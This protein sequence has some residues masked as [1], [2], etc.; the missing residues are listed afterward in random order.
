MGNDTGAGIGWNG[1]KIGVLEGGVT[2]EIRIPKGEWIKGCPG[3]EG[4]GKGQ[5][6]GTR[7]GVDCLEEWAGDRELTDW[8]ADKGALTGVPG[9]D[10]CGEDGCFGVPEEEDEDEDED[11]FELDDGEATMGESQDG[12]AVDG[13]GVGESRLMMLGLESPPNAFNDIGCGES[14]SLSE[15]VSSSELTV[16]SITSILGFFGAGPT[17]KTWSNL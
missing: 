4:E 17:L 7:A 3:G 2:G 1:G 11:E 13:A 12:D 6:L 15:S 16:K 8:G 10:F 5:G 9:R 14:E